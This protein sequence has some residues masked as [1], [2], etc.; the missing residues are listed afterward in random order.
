[1]D[2]IRLHG[3]NGLVR[4]K[5]QW[6]EIGVRKGRNEGKDRSVL[7]IIE[8]IMGVLAYNMLQKIVRY[9]QEEVVLCNVAIALGSE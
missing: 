9:R 4:R 6:K 5:C 8:Q 7:S 2:P 1:M 3:T